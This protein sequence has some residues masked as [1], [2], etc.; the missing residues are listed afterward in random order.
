MRHKDSRR[1]NR[2]YHE[3]SETLVDA[4]RNID[5]VVPLAKK[6]GEEEE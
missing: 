4:V 5:N 6:A 1:T 3:W 2:Y